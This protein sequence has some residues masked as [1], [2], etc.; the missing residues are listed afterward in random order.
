[1][2]STS[3]FVTSPLSTGLTGV[4]YDYVNFDVNQFSDFVAGTY[5]LPVSWHFKL[6][7]WFCNTQRNQIIHS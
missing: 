3:G 6:L 4:F 7:L 5:A 1:M 2:T